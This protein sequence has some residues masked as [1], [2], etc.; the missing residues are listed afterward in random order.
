MIKKIF[1]QICNKLNQYIAKP[2]MVLGYKSPYNKLYLPQTRISNT[3]YLGNPEKLHIADNVYIGHYSILECSN[4]I[5]IA[6]GCQICSNVL[7]TTHSSHLSLRVYGQ[8]Y[9]ANNSGHHGYLRG[10]ITIGAFSFIGPYSTIMPGSKIGK[11]SIVSAYSYVKGEFPDFAIL[12]GNPAQVIGDT[13]ELD[14]ELLEK[15]PELQGYY[16][17]WTNNKRR[18]CFALLAMTVI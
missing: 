18:D 1:W 17:E 9:I 2:R 5:S 14:K 13:R 3:V 4:G 8:H 12:A 15:Y 11:G 7:L 16:D 6:S 10:S